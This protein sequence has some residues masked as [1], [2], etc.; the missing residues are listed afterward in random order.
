MVRRIALGDDVNFVRDFGYYDVVF[1]PVNPWASHVGQFYS[2]PG[3]AAGIG[4]ASNGSAFGVAFYFTPSPGEPGDACEST[5]ETSC[6][7]VKRAPVM[8]AMPEENERTLS[9]SSREANGGFAFISRRA[10]MAPVEAVWPFF[11]R[12]LRKLL[13]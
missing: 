4:G 8:G 2:E 9:V 10:A 3:R 5:G 13:C 1:S 11:S 12:C 7:N 6:R